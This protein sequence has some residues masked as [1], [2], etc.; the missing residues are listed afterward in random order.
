MDLLIML[1]I[2]HLFADFPLQTNALAK[3]KETN[4]RGVLA[5]VG[6]H[7]LVMTLL[8]YNSLHYWPLILGIGLVHF[9]ID[10]GKLIYPGSKGIG[11]F[12]FDQS[13]HLLTL[14]FA[15]YIAQQVWQPAP[16]GIL[17]QAW[18]LP[19]LSAA[20]IPALMVLFW[21]WTNTLSQEYIAQ[22]QILQWSKHQ[23]LGLEQRFGQFLIGL[24]LLEFVLTS[25]VGMRQIGW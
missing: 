2:A 8:I 7:L 6:V 21:V 14:L 19:T 15:A 16:V 22:V 12:L 9:T 17:P 13:L 23:I 18:L 3:F 5:H 11:Y 20:C 1:L 25:W 4:W 24:V 10:L